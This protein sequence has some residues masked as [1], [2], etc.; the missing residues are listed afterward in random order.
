VRRPRPLHGRLS[1]AAAALRTLNPRTLNPQN[2]ETPKP[3]QNVNVGTIVATIWPDTPQ[4]LRD[5]LGAAA[6]KRLSV[7]YDAKLRA[8]GIEGTPDLSGADILRRERARRNGG[9]R[10]RRARGEPA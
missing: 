2:P 4:V 3:R 7:S 9:A 6:F 1:G 10:G 8:F 5:I